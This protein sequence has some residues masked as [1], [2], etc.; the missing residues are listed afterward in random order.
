VA[1]SGKF[2]YV[3]AGKDGLVVLDVSA[4]EH[5]VLMASYNTELQ[6]KRY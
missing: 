2:A 1:L 3:A 5:P 4:P 6:S